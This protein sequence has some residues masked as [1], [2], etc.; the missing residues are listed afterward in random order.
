MPLSG[1]HFLFSD[2][3]LNQMQSRSLE[4]EKARDHYLELL[5]I[6]PESDSLHLKLAGIY[7]LQSKYQ[8]ARQHYQK[9]FRKHPNDVKIGILITITYEQENKPDSAI[10]VIEPL[11]DKYPENAALQLKA[12]SLFE[13]LTEYNKTLIYY[14]RW[15]RQDPENPWA[16]SNIGQV[17]EYLGKQDSAR[18]A[19]LRA[20]EKG[21]TSRSAYK[22]FIDARKNRDTSKVR[23]FQEKT[24]K[25]A[26]L[27]MLIAEKQSLPSV[28]VFANQ[29][30]FLGQNK[31]MDELRKIVRNLVLNWFP[32]PASESLES[33]I[34]HMLDKYP[35]S[36]LLME[37]LAF[38]Y[39]EQKKWDQSILFY[40]RLLSQQPRSE[41]GLKNL[42]SVY[43]NLNQWLKAYQIYQK[44]LNLNLQN[45][46]FYPLVIRTAEAAGQLEILSERWARLYHAHQDNPLLKRYL[47]SIY[48]KMGL[49]D[50]A[51]DLLQKSPE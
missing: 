31:N 34:L 11:S 41:I 17:F 2:S 28:S 19:Y 37:Q 45:P 8:Q 16:D 42:G 33:F 20:E 15:A 5:R 30:I 32:S 14:K 48:Y 12:G 49:N 26:V 9:V 4:F 10:M 24:L 36:P 43:E 40:E 13:Q 47:I 6:H 44:G 38:V 29:Q 50:K 1:Q 46:E 35:D 3:L 22:M 21:G 51:Q 27:E 18:A 39:K 25:R 23:I 7:F